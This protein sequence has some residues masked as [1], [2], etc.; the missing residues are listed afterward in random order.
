[1]RPIPALPATSIDVVLAGD[2]GELVKQHDIAV[3]TVRPT[4]QALAGA[5]DRRGSP[6]TIC[7]PILRWFLV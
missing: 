7:P 1:M 2:C 3:R 6:R 4:Q 5:T